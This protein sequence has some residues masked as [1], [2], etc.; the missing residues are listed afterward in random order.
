M[1]TGPAATLNHLAKAVAEDLEHWNASYIK[2][3]MS[4]VG[5]SWEDYQTLKAE[6]LA[7]VA[8]DG[9]QIG[10]IEDE[11]FDMSC[12]V[13]AIDGELRARLK[14]I[15]EGEVHPITPPKIVLSE[16]SGKLEDWSDWRREFEAKILNVELPPDF[17]TR[18]LRGSLKGVA[19]NALGSPVGDAQSILDQSWQTLCEAYATNTSVGR[20]HMAS[21][22]DYPPLTDGSPTELKKLIDHIACQLDT[23]RKMGYQVSKSSVV[24]GEVTL[25]KVGP[26]FRAKWEATNKSWPEATEVLLFMNRNIA[27]SPSQAV[28][29]VTSKTPSSKPPMCRQCKIQHFYWFCPTF[30]LWKVDQRLKAVEKWGLCPNCLIEDHTAENC[31]ESG[32]PRCDS[33]KHNNMLCPLFVKQQAAPNPTPGGGFLSKASPN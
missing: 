22:L 28:P 29:S 14:A 25:R 20:M 17:K 26:I 23:L 4:R 15:N 5:K 18:A 9:D 31:A 10:Q 8:G 11:V 27:G 1:E 6:L 19:F 3:Q 7:A 32:C 13:E 30:K 2:F 33:A 12:R 24:F 21:I 16:F